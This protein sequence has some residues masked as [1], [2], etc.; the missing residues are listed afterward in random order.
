M[1]TGTHVLTSIKGTPLYM[2]PELI[3]GESYD[4]KVDIWSLGC[5][6]YQ[7]LVGVPPFNTDS[8][9]TL[10]RLICDEQKEQS[11]QWPTFVSEPCITFLKGLLQ[12]D[13]DERFDWEDILNHDFVKGH[14]LVCDDSTNMP[15]TRVMSENTLQAK[16]KQRKDHLNN[17]SLKVK[18][19]TVSEKRKTK[20]TI[21]SILN[22]MTTLH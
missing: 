10:I 4:H 14:I 7:L 8:L 18:K 1:S 9:V 22:Y 15:L 17:K 2:A 13:A 11:L 16:E 3:R 20:T 21:I 5:I 12:K 6:M 19:S